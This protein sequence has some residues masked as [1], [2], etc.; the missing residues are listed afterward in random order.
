MSNYTNLSFTNQIHF[1]E[2]SL[3]FI[4]CR[5]LAR[6]DDSRDTHGDEYDATEAKADKYPCD[7]R[8]DKTMKGFCTQTEHILH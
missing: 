1:L 6:T 5:M 4:T 3:S 8:D 2:D 7:R